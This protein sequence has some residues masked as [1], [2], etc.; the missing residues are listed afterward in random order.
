M[1]FLLYD[2]R[3]KTVKRVENVCARRS[4]CGRSRRAVVV[5]ATVVKPA[6]EQQY[7]KGNDQSCGKGQLVVLVQHCV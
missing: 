5:T 3:L 7:H 6:V 4:S 2:Y 1:R